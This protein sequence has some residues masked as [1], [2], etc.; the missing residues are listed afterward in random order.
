M[1][2]STFKTVAKNLPPH[3]A[4]LMRGPTGI[5]KSQVTR[6]IADELN[7]P[8]IDVRGSTMQ[9]GDVIGYP[10]LEAMKRDGV[11][12]FC[13]PS[14]FIRA[15]KEPCVLML[16]ELNRSMPGVMQGFF[17]IV[18][19][20]ELGND[21]KG[22]PICLHPE[23]RVFAAVNVG[24]EYDVNDMDPALLRR[25]WVA[26]LEPDVNGWMDWARDAGLDSV[27]IEFV[28]QN[29]E[30][31]RVNAAEAEPGSVCPNP[32]SWHRLAETLDHCDWSPRKIAGNSLPSGFYPMLTGFIGTEASIAFADFIKNYEKN[33]TAEDI[34]NG[35]VVADDLEGAPTSHITNV[36]DKLE[37]HCK[38]N[39]WSQKQ[40]KAVA[41]FA[42]CL[43]GELLLQTFTAV[44][45]SNNLDN[46]VKIN[47]IIGREV[48]EIVNAAR[49]VTK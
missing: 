5:G 43:G 8:F 31:W 10:D 16:D 37:H 12:T 47:K 20:R 18:L 42:R 14:W 7:L 21:S 34:I 29:P 35:K 40:C 23:T 26:D 44:Q 15:T 32:A 33:I 38:D 6:S 45:K 28:G 27:L 46:L 17:Q 19:D 4:V 3:I 22:N 1:E 13:L 36:I 49:S 30:H 2:I 11:S 25:F 24:N 48:V 41:E 39:K 9:E